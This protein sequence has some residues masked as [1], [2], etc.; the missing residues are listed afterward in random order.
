MSRPE[1]VRAVQLSSMPPHPNPL[2]RRRR[3]AAWRAAQGVEPE[4]QH[5]SGAAD[6]GAGGERAFFVLF[7][8][9][10]F[11]CLQLCNW[12]LMQVGEG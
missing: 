1:G 8:R 3:H 12:Q 9:A 7:L 5:A 2:R 6:A 10:H 11:L 4:R